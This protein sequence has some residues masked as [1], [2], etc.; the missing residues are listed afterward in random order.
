MLYTDWV[1]DSEYAIMMSPTCASTSGLHYI[2]FPLIC[3]VWL[4]WKIFCRD[5]LSLAVHL[6]EW[7]MAIFWILNTLQGQCSNF[8]HLPCDCKT[9]LWDSCD[10]NS[11]CDHT[12]SHQIAPNTTATGKKQYTGAQNTS[13]TCTKLTAE[14]LDWEQCYFLK[15]KKHSP[16]LFQRGM[17]ST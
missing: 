14:P 1:S 8:Y 4:G 6:L 11:A 9:T 3:P 13:F 10:T 12:S 16:I 2:P 15:M 17:Q 7:S 5:C